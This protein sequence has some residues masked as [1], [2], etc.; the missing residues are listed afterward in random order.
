MLADLPEGAGRMSLIKRWPADKWFSDCV[1]KRANWSCER[2]HKGYSP[3]TSALH[4]CHFYSRG[5]WSTR[6]DPM[7]AVSLD[8][9]CHLYFTGRPSEFHA[10]YVARVGL[11]EVERLQRAAKQPAKGLKK[12]L[13]DI[14]K[15]YK[16]T[17]DEMKLGGHF[18]GYA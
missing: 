3:P 17:Y 6:F 14:A 18:A 8:M 2:C 11:E 4:C 10:W 16:R 7:N 1:R 5:N 12:Q 13:P 9:G 15:F